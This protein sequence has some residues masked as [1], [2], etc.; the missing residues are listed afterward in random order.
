MSSSAQYRNFISDALRTALLSH[1]AVL[2]I[3]L[4]IP[5]IIANRFGLLYL[6]QI[7]P[8][9]MLFYFLQY[10]IHFNFSYSMN[11]ATPGQHDDLFTEWENA[12]RARTTI[13][14]I[15]VSTLFLLQIPIIILVS[16]FLWSLFRFYNL[17][18]FFMPGGDAHL[19]HRIIIEWILHLIG[20]AILIVYPGI[21]TAEI[22]FN[23]LAGLELLKFLIHSTITGVNFKFPLLP[24]V[25]FT[26]I[27]QNTS[28]FISSLVSF[29]KNKI[30][31]LPAILIL[32]G[33]ALGKFYMIFL[34]VMA[35]IRISY[36]FMKNKINSFQFLNNGEINRHSLKF[37]IYGSLVS[38]IWT[39]G[40]YFL[41][42]ATN[43][44]LYRQPELMIPVFLISLF[45]FYN[46]PKEYL[47]IKYREGRNIDLMNGILL[48]LQIVG[49]V[50]AFSS[51]NSVHCFWILLITSVLYTISIHYFCR[52][53]V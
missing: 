20:L 6:G 22:F 21:F 31:L 40:G 36:P 39:C 42:A 41:L 4:C 10:L 44:D 9:Y 35:G 48:P 47:L 46:I 8:V 18:Y 1:G 32:P 28:Y 12:I 43:A 23:I 37:T 26:V 3:T 2:L 38:F 13:A 17:S 53:L 24:R 11:T 52:K 14:F 33:L 16:G 27:Q 25:N 34:W 29:L 15:S 49:S 19:P 5:A 30:I 45:S 50:I 51:G 7:L